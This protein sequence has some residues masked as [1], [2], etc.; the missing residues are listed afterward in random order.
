MCGMDTIKKYLILVRK[1]LV[2]L[3]LLLEKWMFD[4]EEDEK[5]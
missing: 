4:Y 2:Y 5:E 3:F 1:N